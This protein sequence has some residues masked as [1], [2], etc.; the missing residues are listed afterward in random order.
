[1]TSEKTNS[2]KLT[3]SENNLTI[4]ANTPEVGEA[5]ESIAIKYKGK[6]FAIAFNPVF[7]MEGL[8]ALDDDEVFLEY[9]RDP[10]ERGFNILLFDGIVGEGTIAGGLDAIERVQDGLLA[11]GGIGAGR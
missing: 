11:P 1:M 7:L 6:E 8:K 2:V 3:F 10:R 4:T 5:R 9:R